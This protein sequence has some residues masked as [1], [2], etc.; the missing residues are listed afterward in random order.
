[1]NIAT[2]LQAQALARPQQPALIDGRRSLTYAELEQATAAV[3]AQMQ[4]AGLCSGERVLVFVPMSADLYIILGAI[5]RLGLVAVF[6]DPSAGR[7]HI[8]RCCT[9]LP[10]RAFVGTTQAHLLRFVVPALRRIPLA[11]SVGRL[12]ILGA[13]TITYTPRPLP[14]SGSAGD[15]SRPTAPALI[16]FTSGSTGQP[17]AVARSHAFLIEQHRVLAKHLAL[18]PGAIDLATLP[19]FVL[20]NLAS[21]LTTLIPATNL[22]KPGAADPVPIVQQVQQYRATSLAA[23]PALLAR[24]AAYCQ[25][26]NLTLPTLHKVFTGGAPVFPA[27]LQ[28]VQ[29]IAP[30]A[31]VVAVYGS[32]EAEP[33]AHISYPQMG[34][35]DMARMQQGAGLLAGPPVEDI[36][37]RIM[38]DQWGTP[39]APLRAAAFQAQCLPAGAA[40]EIVVSGAH[41]LRGY[42]D[43]RGDQETKFQVVEANGTLTTWHRTGDAGY[44]DAAGRLWLLGRCA[45]RLPQ[46]DGVLYPFTV[47]CALS[48]DA[49][50]RRS[51]VVTNAGRRVLLVELTNTHP[52]SIALI[53]EVCAWA[54][55]DEVR[56]YRELPVDKRHNAKIDYTALHALLKQRPRWQMTL[57]LQPAN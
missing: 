20:A 6:L 29:Q 24:V 1:M 50:V 53:Q 32:T 21:G 46:T 33:I 5:F 31:E 52:L 3:A 45:A 56:G 23:S 22:Q 36:A 39:L 35:D 54:S 17:K 55:I 30:H 15:H 25:Q 18:R 34:A 40:G 16:T 44:L 9:M 4:A 12:P 19:I 26:H 2:I 41:V 8:E 14:G 11:F 48:F 13:H 57:R 10:P 28:Q 27:L 43:G 51:A 49:Q 37:L 7:A 38:P 47:E 42:V